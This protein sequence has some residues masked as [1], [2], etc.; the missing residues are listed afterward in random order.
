MSD[1]ATGEVTPSE[2]PGEPE[3]DAEPDEQLGEP[4]KRALDR[5]REA[6]KAAEARLREFE[7]SQKS[8]EQKRSEELEQ[9]RKQVAEHAEHEQRSKWAAAV[10]ESTGV[11]A[12]VLRGDSEEALIEHAEAITAW[13]SHQTGPVVKTEGS[14]PNRPVSSGDW[15]RNQFNK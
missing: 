11:P 6:R 9:L 12:A 14:Q 5:E 2:V 10:S 13:A 8:E 4:G 1:I 15:L 7:E 3:Q